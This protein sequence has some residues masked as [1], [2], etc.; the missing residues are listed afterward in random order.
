MISLEGNGI[1]PEGNGILR[2]RP[3]FHGRERNF[4]GALTKN[5]ALLF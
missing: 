3:R 4:T 1:S 5:V 2:E